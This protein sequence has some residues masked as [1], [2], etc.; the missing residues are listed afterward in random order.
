M[1]SLGPSQL[2]VGF[3]ETVAL[4]ALRRGTTYEERSRSPRN[5]NYDPPSGFWGYS[6]VNAARA[7]IS[8]PYCP[9]CASRESFEFG[10]GQLKS[11]VPEKSLLCGPPSD[12]F[13]IACHPNDLHEACVFLSGG[14]EC[15]DKVIKLLSRLP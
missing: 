11:A 1:R 7:A 13:F 2:R 5:A 4:K 8:R 12:R 3:G 10:D 6:G 9:A 15:A 14:A